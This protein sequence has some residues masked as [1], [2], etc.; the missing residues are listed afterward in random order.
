M[1]DS[2]LVNLI[3]CDTLTPPLPLYI[4]LAFT[5][6]GDGLNDGWTIVN[7]P[8]ENQVIIT[9]KWGGEVML[10]QMNYQND[11]KGTNSSDTKLPLG[12]YV[13]QVIYTKHPGIRYVKKGW[14]T[15][16]K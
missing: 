4:P 3:N 16:L 1:V 15:M 13:Y 6:N 5:P 14:V 7:L 12:V 9:N 8:E 2:V 10:N 11:W